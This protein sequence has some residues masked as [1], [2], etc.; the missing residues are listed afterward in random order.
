[1]STEPDKELVDL[2]LAADALVHEVKL[3]AQRAIPTLIKLKR[4]QFMDNPE[5]LRLLQTLDGNE[6]VDGRVKQAVRGALTATIH[7]AVYK[8]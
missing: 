8:E 4:R 1:M 7:G 3:A 2:E 6:S 5:A